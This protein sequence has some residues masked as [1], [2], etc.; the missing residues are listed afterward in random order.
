MERKVAM[1][2]E[3]LKAMRRSQADK[4]DRQ[5]D[6]IRRVAAG[7]AGAGAESS[8]SSAG[9]GAGAADGL[10]ALQAEVMA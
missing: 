8:K 10:A 7:G 6:G 5:A 9:T 4:W 1:E 2:L 3:A